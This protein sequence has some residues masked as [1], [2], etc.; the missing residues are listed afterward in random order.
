[1]T[2]LIFHT[3]VAG[4]ATDEPVP[5]V[6]LL[7]G[8]T[9]SV[10]NSVSSIISEYLPEFVTSNHQ[11]F[12]SF[13]EA[14]YEWMEHIEN[15]LG[16]SITFMDDLDIDRTLDSFVEYFKNN[17]LYS[18]PKKFAEVSTNSVDEK[19]VLKNVKDFYKS[20]GTEKAYK[21]LFRILHDSDVSFYYPKKDILRVSDGK[22]IEKKSIKITSNNGTSNFDMKNKR[23][24]QIDSTLGGSVSAYANVDNVYQYQIQQYSVTELFLVDINGTFTQGSKVKCTLDD[25]TDLEENIYTIPS[26]IVISGGGAGY[27][28]LDVINIDESSSEYVGGVGAKGKVTKVDANGII[29]NAQIDEFGVDYRNSEG[30]TTLPIVF[31]SASG[32]GATGY[33]KIDALCTYPGYYANNDGKVSSNKKLRDNDLYQEYSYVLKAEV[34]LDSYRNQIKKL[35]HPAGTKMFG[36]ISLFDS[37]T[38]TNTYSTGVFQTKIPIIGRYTPYTLDTHDNLIAATG[39]GTAVDLYPRGFNPGST[40]A[41]HC[42]GNTGG[43]LAIKTVGA[44]GGYTLGS[45]RVGEGITGST[46]GVSGSIFGW[47]RNSSTGGVLFL[48]TVGTGPALGFT[49]GEM[50]TATGGMTGIVEFVTVGN[51]TVYEFGSTTHATGPAWGYTGALTGGATAFGATA[52][53]DI[54]TGWQQEYGNISETIETVDITHSTAYTAGWDYTIGNTVIQGDGDDGNL[55]RGIVK[56]WIPGASGATGNILKI[57]KTSGQDFVA[58]TITEINTYGGEGISYTFSHGGTSGNTIRNKIKH[59]TLDELKNP[60][61]EFHSDHGYTV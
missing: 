49:T 42:L 54:E 33:V 23:I 30:K 24:E 56:D 17:Y 60:T 52:Y 32:S 45:F 48:N 55:T 43:R 41:N 37:S 36:N 50:I 3:G 21:F 46:T 47:S 34:S 5:Q 10:E 31:K 35:A 29:Q 40:A 16:T 57:Q 51:G 13:I 4:S 61:W 25:G 2:Y 27:R 20:K 9:A 59:I 18:F 6:T 1:M 44:T 22:W 19:T 11:T 7:A 58:G 53:W 12:V 14:Y 26:D 38:T 8:S 28:S 15:P 39:S